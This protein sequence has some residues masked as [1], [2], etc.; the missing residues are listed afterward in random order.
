MPGKTRAV[1]SG[2]VSNE[3]VDQWTPL[4]VL[5]PGDVL[6]LEMIVRTWA[7]CQTAERILAE[8]GPTFTTETGLHR[9]ATRN[10]DLAQESPGP[11]TV[12]ERDLRHAIEPVQSRFATRTGG[13]ERTGEVSGV[14]EADP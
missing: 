7:T 11:A 2:A 13:T 14:R 12:N 6:L 10:C 5:K 8:V 9:P 1:G 3:L 4:G